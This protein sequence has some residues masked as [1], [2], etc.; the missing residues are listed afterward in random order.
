MVTIDKLNNWPHSLRSVLRSFLSAFISTVH[1]C[2]ILLTQKPSSSHVKQSS[3]KQLPFFLSFFFL[4]V[5]LRGLGKSSAPSHT[6]HI[7]PVLFQP[8]YPWGNHTRTGFPHKVSFAVCSS[9]HL[10]VLRSDPSALVFDPERF[11]CEAES[12]MA[13][14][15][16]CIQWRWSAR[17]LKVLKSH[18]V[19]LFIFQL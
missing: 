17:A 15:R 10:A 11:P 5:C 19:F 18:C 13:L 6:V 16:L 2:Q 7:I 9:D 3:L 1:H 14:L 12:E 8:Y 4:S